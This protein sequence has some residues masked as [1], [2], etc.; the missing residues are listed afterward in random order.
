QCA[1]LPK[2]PKWLPALQISI[3][4][5]GLVFNAVAMFV[6]IMLQDFKKSIS[7]LYV[8]QL[9][10]ADSLFL[11]MLPFKAAEGLNGYWSM[12][13]FLCHIQQAVFML[14]YYAGIFFL[15]VMSFDRYVAIVHPVSAPWRKLRTHGNA[16]VI[17]LAVWVLAIAVSI[18]LFVWSD[19]NCKCTHKF[20]KSDEEFRRHHRNATNIN[21][22]TDYIDDPSQFYE[23][24]NTLEPST[25][26]ELQESAVEDP[27]ACSNEPW[28]SM[29]I[30]A[31]MHFVF[32]FLLP[33][34]IMTVCYSL[35]TWRVMHPAISSANRRTGNRKGSSEAT[36][37]RGGKL[38]RSL[39]FSSTGSNRSAN[40]KQT[41]GMAQKSRVTIIVVSLVLMFLVCW[42]PYNIV[43]LVK[44]SRLPFSVENCMLVENLTIVLVYLNSMINPV[45]YTFLGSRFFRR[46]SKARFVFCRNRQ[47]AGTWSSSTQRSTTFRQRM[48]DARRC[49]TTSARV[50][51]NSSST[52]PAATAT[53]GSLI[54]RPH[55]N[56]EARED[57]FRPY[58]EDNADCWH[59]TED[60]QLIVET[61]FLSP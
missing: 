9:A 42:M 3:A 11:A 36:S 1:G 34:T 44:F 43:L 49:R 56:I 46:F 19:V 37:Q 27:R 6:I 57:R 31:G 60:P 54:Y 32:A 29:K 30:W 25:T 20:P 59:G 7:H 26:R 23:L 14:N 8:L 39:R 35:I 12:P 51:E 53:T 41:P 47:S 18:P 5:C 50:S 52:V 24:M 10:I 55:D 45:L 15:T 48:A 2:A 28:V 40:K 61:K 58:T 21:D 4:L 17:T 33:F 16:V 22:M 13:H 38:F